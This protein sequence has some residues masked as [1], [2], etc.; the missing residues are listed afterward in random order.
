M[1][2]LILVEDTNDNRPIFTAVPSEAILVKENEA[3]G[4]VA[5]FEATDRDSG[6]FGQVLLAC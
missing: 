3:A 4:T 6:A 5:T 1:Q 2:V